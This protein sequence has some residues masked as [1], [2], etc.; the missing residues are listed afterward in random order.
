MAT[1]PMSVVIQQL[2]TAFGRDEAELTDG[3]LLTLFLNNRD[4]AALAALVRRHAS[5]V[6][7]VCNRMLRSHHDAEDAFQATFLVLVRKAATV[8]PREAVGNWLYGVAHQT[9]VRLRATAAKKGGRERQVVD[10]PEPVVKASSSNDL[11]P[12]LDQELSCLPKKYRGLIVLCHLESKTLKEVARQLSI[13][14][15]TVAG[16]LARAKAMLAKRLAR[17]GVTVSGGT[18]AAVLAQSAASASAPT[19]LVAATIKATSL[20][21]AGQAVSAGLVSAKVIALTKGMVQAMFM[22][23]IKN[24]L[25]VVLIVGVVLGGAM[26]L[27][28]G[29]FNPRTQ[30][31]EQTELKINPPEAKEESVDVAAADGPNGKDKDVKAELMKLD[32]GWRLVGLEVGGKSVNP[33]TPAPTFRYFSGTESTWNSG[34]RW[35]K[36]QIKINPAKTPKWIDETTTVG[37]G[38]KRFLGVYE[39]KADTLRL[40]FAPAGEERPTAFKTKEGTQQTILI[41]E[42]ALWPARPLASGESPLPDRIVQSDIV[43]WGRVVA[44]EPKDVE[45][46]LHPEDPYK[47]KLDYRIAVVK[48]HE[49]IHGQKEVKELRL[50]FVSPDQDR[51]VDKTGKVMD[52]PNVLPAVFRSVNVGGDGVFFLRKHHEGK[53]F[54]NFVLFDN[55]PPSS[56]IPEFTK[57]I[58]KARRLS[59]FLEFPVESLKDENGL[60]RF[61]AATMLINRHRRHGGQVSALKKMTEKAIDAEESKLLLKT[62]AEADWQT[63]NDAFSSIMYPPHPYYVFLRLGVT[64]ADGYDPPTNDDRKKLAY[65]QRWLQDQQEKYRIKRFSADAK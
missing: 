57:D 54:V 60:N 40:F 11:L 15:G 8:V 26:G 44:L 39:L 18:M 45:A 21:A 43:V 64:K 38:E 48:V 49:V 47:Y 33:E 30:A 29:L 50:G 58:E 10:M 19:T 3:E 52:H 25:A 59:K 53:F 24:V 46:V 55:F 36:G 62:L 23:K 20:M 65:T 61:L 63:G 28:I 13:P 41:F 17:R 34:L 32:G 27:G 4:D 35:G 22:S 37:A 9:A 51:K 56:N 12:L 14:E 42:R 2:R 5:M 16:R 6:W 1:S 7:G 31:G